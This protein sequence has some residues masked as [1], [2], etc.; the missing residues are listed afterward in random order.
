MYN[1]NVNKFGKQ[2]KQEKAMNEN[3]VLEID[4]ATITMASQD[5]KSTVEEPQIF[6]ETWN[7][8]DS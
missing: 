2:A 7:H 8:P 1:A 3:L 4:L 6:N 5:T